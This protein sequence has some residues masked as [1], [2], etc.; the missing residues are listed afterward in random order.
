LR[1]ERLNPEVLLSRPSAT[2]F[3]IG[4]GGEGRGEEELWFM[5]DGEEQ[6]FLME[7]STPNF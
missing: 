1:F 6:S 3:S 4:N 7:K 2:L 5:G